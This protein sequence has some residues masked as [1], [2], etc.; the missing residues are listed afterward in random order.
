MLAKIMDIISFWME[1]MTD[2]R[3]EK[4]FALHEWRIFEMILP[5]KEV[6]NGH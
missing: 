2:R 6:Y 3:A 1:S 5:N 4:M